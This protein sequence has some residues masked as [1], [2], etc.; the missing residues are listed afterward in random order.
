MGLREHI[1]DIRNRLKSNQYPGGKQAVR[2]GIIDRL[3]SN[4]SW[5]MYDT[6]IVYP[7][8][9]VGGGN[10]DY[11]LCHPASTPRVFIEAKKLGTLE[12][13]DERPEEQLFGYDSHV[14][15]S[16]AVLTDGKIWRFFN[17]AGTGT[18]ADRRVKE[19]NLAA[20]DTE[21]NIKYLEKYLSHEAVQAGRAEKA[22]Q[23]DYDALEHQKRIAKHLP[24]AWRNLVKKSD[25]DNL[26]IELVSEETK[27]LCG[28]TPSNEQ[29]RFF[30]NSLEKKMDPVKPPPQ[31]G[32][33]EPGHHLPRGTNGN[34]NAETRLHVTMG[35][36]EIS[37]HKALDTFCEV[38]QRLGLERVYEI[39]PRVVSKGPFPNGKHKQIDGYWINVN[40]GTPE[41]KRKLDRIAEKLEFGGTWNV[42]IVDK[43]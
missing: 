11:A 1:E 22:L 41:K 14:R 10:V 3:L 6:K 32:Y 4:L 33:R 43:F 37:H 25:S 34:R 26:L 40:N 13:T 27:E 5:P 38:L 29:V 30:L 39:E 28:D 24:K 12:K 16:I 36:L 8:Y 9:P 31:G 21:E 18:W 17:P 15:V 2:Q 7:E 23:E 35:D 42:E 19:L 20:E